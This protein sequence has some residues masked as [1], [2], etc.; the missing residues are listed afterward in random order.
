M[1][2]L[3]AGTLLILGSAVVLIGGIGL[4]RLPDGFSRLHA[5]GVIDTLGAWLVLLGLLVLSTSVVVAF[6]VILLI[7]LLYFLSP[8]N[9]HGLSR[10]ALKSGLRPFTDKPS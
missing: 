7:I 4:L 2:D 9:S 10:T 8:V 5:V 3:L 6:K 1:I